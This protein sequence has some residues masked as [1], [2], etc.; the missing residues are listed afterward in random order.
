[1]KGI[2]K[3]LLG[4]AAALALVLVLAAVLL[5]LM[6]DKEDL[7]QAIASQVH[8][9][10]GRDLRI[11]GAL[12]FSVFPW[13]AVEAADLRLSNAAG[14]GDQPFAS[15]GKVRIGV[16]LMPL[17][18]KQLVADEITLDGLQLALAVNARGKNNWDDLAAGG[19]EDT[20]AANE[21]LG[22]ESSLFASQRIAGLT[23]RDAQIDYQDQ[24]GGTHWRADH[25]SLQTGALGDALLIPVEL[26]MRL[27]DLAAGTR[28]GIDLSATAGLDLEAQT[29][30]FDDAQLAVTPM[31][32]D[33]GRDQ[34]ASGM[35]IKLRMP[36]IETRLKAETLAVE[37]FTASLADLEAT[38]SIK[39]RN[40][41]HEPAFEG[42]L[43]LADFSPRKLL[44]ALSI[45]APVTADPGVLQRAS[46]SA[47]MSGSTAQLSLGDFHG[48]L[49][50]SAFSGK[51][52]V[53]NFD[54]PRI[55]FD[56]A[57]DAIDL[58]RYQEPAANQGAAQTDV[59]MPAQ[60][61]Q[62]LDVQGSLKAG[63]LH[64][65]GM[66]FTNAVVGLKLSNGKLRLNPLTAGFYDGLYSGNVTL[67]SSGA[68]PVLSLDEK[69]DSVT[70]QRLLA[71][72]TH[73]EKLS[74]MAQAQ[75][76]L[77]GR[78]TTSSE[79]LNSLTG[80]LGMTL[81]EGALEGV[82]IWYEIRRGYALY[83][84]LTPPEPEP[85]RTVFS[86]MQMDAGVENGVLT[87]RE[88]S[89]EMPFLSVRGGGS[90]NLAQSDV[91]MRLTAIVRKAPEL[92]QDPL[93]AGLEGKQLPFKVSGSLAQPK[94]SVDWAEL[95]K[96]EAADKLLNKLGLKAKPAQAG[97]DNENLSPKEKNKEAAKGLLRD[98][99]RGKDKKKEPSGD[100]NGGG[101]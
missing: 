83:K 22:S 38:G 84:G 75:V 52:S 23:L 10:T 50:Q 54:R 4:L 18:K 67:D 37:S 15:I 95:L 62:D 69:L 13:L 35:A 42:T 14:F 77:T 63:T 16:A 21:A 70:L 58:D 98:L 24:K 30:T 44:Q 19:K 5:P 82:N 27:E 47:S 20:T 72:I 51:M 73:S 36:R 1:M 9:Q 6:Y 96:S 3:I 55:R 66:D 33:A 99:L 43:R 31:A 85:A 71:D 25:V 8:K 65:A 11:E 87:T 97:G 91:D 68:K 2:L 45:E 90:I 32:A 79:V 61:L 94:V 64:L 86:R 34:T 41:L 101:S 89:A 49:D 76:R 93:G 17:F 39:A 53:Q 60:N 28:F 56:F 7:K 29:Y 40:I 26:S 46:F 48:E 100:E 59:V 12:N 80:D 74:G 92:A 57:V 88:L 78:G 81:K